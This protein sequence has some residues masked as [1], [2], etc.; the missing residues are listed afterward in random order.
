M[1]EIKAQRSPVAKA[2]ASGWDSSAKTKWQIWLDICNNALIRMAGYILQQA[3]AK[4][5]GT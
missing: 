5:T 1:T 3:V 2:K 4:F